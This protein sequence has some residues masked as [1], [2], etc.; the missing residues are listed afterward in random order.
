MGQ[1]YKFSLVYDKI[2]PFF[3]HWPQKFNYHVCKYDVYC[4]VND[5]GKDA[6]LV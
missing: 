4:Y 2:I 5:F 6:S 1:K 3:L